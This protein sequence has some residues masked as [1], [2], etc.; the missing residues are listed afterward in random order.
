M[1]ESCKESREPNRKKKNMR[2]FD[3]MLS[4]VLLICRVLFYVIP[5]ILVSVAL[6]LTKF[7]ETEYFTI[8]D[9]DGEGLIGGNM[10]AD[11]NIR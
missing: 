1:M 2:S 10:T 8:Y 4:N 5:V 9:D 6:N 7:F 3:Y 11:N